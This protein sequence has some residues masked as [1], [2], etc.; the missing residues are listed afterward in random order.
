MFD[1]LP[2]REKVGD[3]R[4]DD[5]AIL[6]VYIFILFEEEYA[7]VR[8]FA[9]QRR[10]PAAG[11]AAANNDDVIHTMCITETLIRFW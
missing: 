8:G 2:V 10:K 1:E 9:K 7:E 11:N 5:T 6:Q 3:V 4:R